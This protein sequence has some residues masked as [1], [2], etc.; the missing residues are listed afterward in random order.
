MA[1]RERPKRL[2]V[3]EY[4]QWLGHPTTRKVHRYYQDARDVAAQR[5]ASG[6]EMSPQEQAYAA[7]IGDVLTLDASEV[8]AFYD[9]NFPQQEAESAEE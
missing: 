2:E 6:E 9:N 3:E 1:S 5:W 7:A 4:R 8:E